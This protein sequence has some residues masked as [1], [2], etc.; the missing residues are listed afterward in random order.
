MLNLFQ[1]RALVAKGSIVS[2]SPKEDRGGTAGKVGEVESE[3]RKEGG[4]GQRSQSLASFCVGA[5]Q[6]IISSLAAFYR[7]RG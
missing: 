3:A 2:I 1:E 7:C 5:L 4:L 6:I